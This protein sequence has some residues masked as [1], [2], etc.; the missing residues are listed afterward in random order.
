MQNAFEAQQRCKEYGTDP[1]RGLTSDQV[2]HNRGRYGSNELSPPKREPLWKQYLSKFQDTTIIILTVCAGL[3]LLTGVYRG[4]ATGE[5]LGILEAVAIMI[6]VMIATGVSF[7]LEYKADQAFELLKKESENVP[8]KVTRD[9]VFRTTRVN[10]LVVGDLVHLEGGDKIPADGLIIESSCLKVDQSAI[11]GEPEPASKDE[12]EDPELISGTDVVE[13]NAAMVVTAVGDDSQR[14]KIAKELGET[15]RERTPLEQKLDALADLINVAGTAAAALIF[16]SIFGAGIMQGEVGGKLDPAGRT[17]MLIVAPLVF[18]VVIAYSLLTTA[19]RERP[20]RNIVLGWGTVFVVGLGIVFLWGTPFSGPDTVINN[21]LSNVFS[22]LLHYFMLAVTIIVVAVPEGLPMAITISL[23]LSMRKIRQDNNLVRKMIATETLGSTNIICSDKTGTL[24]LNRMSVER[25]FVHGQLHSRGKDGQTV[26]LR[27]HPAFDTMAL[28]AARNSTANLE[29]KDGELK[30]VGN[31]TECA[32]LKWLRD[33]GVAYEE[34]RERIPCGERIEFTS[35][36]KMMSTVVSQNG[37]QLVLSKGA[38]ER[39]LERCTSI[40]VAPGRT[41]PIQPHLGELNGQLD[42]ITALAMRPL[43]LAYKKMGSGD[44][45]A[46]H[47]LTLLGLVGISDPVRTDVP[48]AVQQCKRAG[49]QVKMVTG[50]HEKTARVIADQVGIMDPDSVVKTGEQFD[51]M[52]DDEIL[53]IAPR[54]RVLARFNPLQKE[55]LVRLLQST[56]EVV[57][58]T[59]DGTN[60]APALRRAD[61]GISMGLRGTD[62]AKEASDVVLV[63]D[64]FASIVRAVHWGRALYENVQK[65]LQFQLTINLSALIIAFLSP[66]LATILAVLRQDWGITI[67]PSAD[68]K[69]LP[70]SILQLLWINLI[71]DTLAA[72][73][74]SLEPKREELMNEPPKR[75]NESFITRSMAENT[76]VMSAYFILVILVMQAA[77]WYLGA[78]SSDPGQVGSVLFTTYVFMQV[79]NLFNAR[80]VRPDRSAFAGVQQSRNFWVVLVFVVVVQVLLTEFGGSTFGTAPLPFHIWINIIMVGVSALLLGELSRYVRR[81]WHVSKG[82]ASPKGAPRPESRVAA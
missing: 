75:R 7:I 8:V 24:T 37:H 17:A 16:A 63:D 45:H 21:F 71:M 72:L 78:D 12:V 79:F 25:V 54:L 39:I 13:G 5:W 32:L 38:P 77:G 1:R 80:S 3:A 26:D 57:A 6:A 34:L 65:F 20:V 48:E 68:F 50:D 35:A 74:L 29:D 42:E 81:Q 19:G 56:G 23:A 62:I 49:I 64:N 41:E 69:E 31:H 11:T 52:S 27:Q 66:L 2:L 46:E 33:Q 47:D 36:R 53:A 40:E 9:G 70:L 73:A 15:E 55:R 59:G 51:A 67:L 61:V 43:A 14:G 76:L 18:V 22:P 4:V 10:D 82:Q 60:D 58:V 28:I 30:F 44:E